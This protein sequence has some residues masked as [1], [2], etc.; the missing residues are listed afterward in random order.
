MRTGRVVSTAWRE[1]MVA[2]RQRKERKQVQVK[3]RTKWV[4]PARQA[5]RRRSWLGRLAVAAVLA[6]LALPGMAI[7]GGG[8]AAAAGCQTPFLVYTDPDNPGMVQET[9]AFQM[10]SGSGLLGQ[11]RGEGRFAGYTIDGAQDA[12]VN[13]ATGM[14]NVRGVFIATSPDGGSSIEV[15]YTGQVDFGARMAHG[16]FTASGE[17]GADIGYNASGAIEGTVVGPATLDGAD[18][19]LC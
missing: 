14:A 17:S 1:K 19:G 10:V 13:T 6:T 3:E 12:V 4:I 2:K 18:I 8:H 5:E 16:V 15:H 11:Y 7:S 9:G